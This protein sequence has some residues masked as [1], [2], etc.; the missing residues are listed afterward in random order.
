MT[1]GNI[2][3]DAGH[4]NL[5]ASTSEILAIKNAEI[6]LAKY[7]PPVLLR[8]SLYI[9]HPIPPFIPEIRRALLGIENT[10][11]NPI[12]DIVLIINSNR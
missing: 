2:N 1:P 10:S 4:F 11:A 12:A 6:K 3:M 7:I 5:L 9:I 8:A